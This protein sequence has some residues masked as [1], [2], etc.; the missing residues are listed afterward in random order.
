MR[1]VVEEYNLYT[2]VH[3]HNGSNLFNYLHHFADG[4]LQKLSPTPI[5]TNNQLNKGQKTLIRTHVETRFSHLQNDF[6]HS[7]F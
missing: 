4:I 7:D 6:C 5:T 3:F 1:T 2:F